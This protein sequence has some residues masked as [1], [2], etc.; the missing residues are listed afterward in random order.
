M[1][2]LIQRVLNALV[3]THDQTVQIDKGLLVYVSFHPKD[4][5]SDLL[6]LADKLFKLRIFDDGAGKMN[7]NVNDINGSILIVPNFTLEADA[8]AGNRPSF[9]QA[10]PFNEALHDFHTFAD[11]L[12]SK[13]PTQ[14]AFF[15]ADMHVESVNDGPVNLIIRSHDHGFSN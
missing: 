1:T 14:R 7:L 5:S 6:K 15:G 11:F 8:L 2:L 3:A 12:A 13:G 4:E 9:S 10:K